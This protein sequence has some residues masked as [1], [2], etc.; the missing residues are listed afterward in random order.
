M[1]NKK[2]HKFNLKTFTLNN[3]YNLSIKFFVN[4]SFKKKAKKIIDSGEVYID[5]ISKRIEVYKPKL[6]AIWS[7]IN[8]LISKL[9]SKDTT[10]M[11]KVLALSAI[12]YLISPID[13]IPDVL[14][15]GLLDD[16]CVIIKVAMDILNHDI[17]TKEEK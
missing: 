16:I 2:K 9:S 7:D 6:K 3:L 1:K 4:G 10:T 8:Y 17:H 14:G 5:K 15:I 11:H 12:I 13:L